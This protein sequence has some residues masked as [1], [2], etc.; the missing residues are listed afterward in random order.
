MSSLSANWSASA[1]S[2]QRARALS[3][4]LPYVFVALGSIL[5]LLPFVRM[6]AWC[7]DE[8]VSEYGAERILHGVIPGREFI[9]L[10]A[11]GAY[12]WLALFFK[13]FGASVEVARGFLLAEGVATV[14]LV[15]YLARR[16]GGVGLFAAAFVLVTSIPFA[17]LNT[18][19]YDANLFALLSFA[20]FLAAERQLSRA[21][22]RRRVYV[23]LFLS[24]TIAGWTSC[25]MQQKGLLFFA[26]FALS[27]VLLHRRQA[28]VPLLTLFAG[29]TLPIASGLAFY[30]SHG[31]LADLIYANFTLPASLYIRI[32]TVPYGF[33]LWVM[34]APGWFAGVR[35]LAPLPLAVLFVAI[36]MLPFLLILALPVLVP[37]LGYFQRSQAF[38]PEWWPYWLAAF[39]LWAS[40][41]HRL[42]LGHLRNGTV[43]LT[44]LFFTLCEKRAKPFL[45]QTA[46][47][48]IACTIF[49]AAINALGAT[50]RHTLL[51]GRHGD[52]LGSK[53]DKALEFLMDHTRTGDDVFIYPY[54]P[55]Y[56]F[57]AGLHNPTRL[58]V[59][60]YDPAANGLFRQAIHDID[61]RKVRYVL[62]DS[63][64]TGKNLLGIFP[65]YRE[66]PPDK[67]IIEPYLRAR[68]HQIAFENGFHI[69]ERNR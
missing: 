57:Y 32:N 45:Q 10:Y 31:A 64:L 27:I 51:H 7:P 39:A 43:L 11:P 65:A 54:R 53:P 25:I 61:T 46:S 22:H 60:L 48:V 63:G 3:K 9:E 49:M 62:W 26:A 8:G 42:D 6:L 13:L 17:V 30:T 36:L 5:Y 47:V 38:R 34:I 18:P 44:L 41:L 68:Y 4:F 69:L 50:S 37:L 1:F 19:H 14:L 12:Y 2:T 15:F 24:G 16:L 52:L 33:P 35:A 20:V 21:R 28:V 59:Y 58:A 67:L 56:Y 29:F 66:P 23:L 40:E 55:F